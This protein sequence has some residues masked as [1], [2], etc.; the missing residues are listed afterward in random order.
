MNNLPMT[1]YDCV[2]LYESLQEM[3]PE[4]MK[5]LDVKDIF[6]GNNRRLSLDDAREYE[7]LLKNKLIELKNNYSDKIDTLLSKFKIDDSNNS[8]A[9]LYALFK[10]IKEK[11]LIPCIVFQQ[12]TS[13]CKEIY[14][15][16][17][18]YLEKL[19][20]FNYPYYYEN[21]E[22]RQKYF[23]ESEKTLKK[24]RNNIKVPA[25][26]TNPVQFIE[27]ELERKRED[28]NNKFSLDFIKLVDKQ[29]KTIQNSTKTDAIKTIQ[30]NN[31][32][33]DLQEFMK[34]PKLRYVDVF[35]KHRDFCLNYDNPMSAD[36]IREIKKTISKK[37]DI[38]VTY[39]NA[40]MQGLKRGI[41][42]YTKH[43]PPIYNMVVQRLAQN[44][45]LGFVV[46]DERLALG[47]NMPFRATCILGYKDSKYFSTHN[48]L[49]MIGRSGRR[50][51]D[52]EGHI[53]FANV[54]WRNLMKS[55]LAEIKSPYKHIENYTV[56]KEFTNS[57]DNTIENIYKFKMTE[58]SEDQSLIT[59]F[60]FYN[61]K[62]L[63][64]DPG[65]TPEYKIVPDDILNA[66]LWKLRKFN[67]RSRILC[68]KLFELNNN[69][70]IEANHQSVVLLVD[71]LIDIL[72]KNTS[73]QKNKLKNIL[74]SNKLIDNSYEEY[75]LIHNIMKIIKTIYNSLINDSDDNYNFLT[76]HLKL[77]FNYLKTIMFNSND[78]N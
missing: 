45:E 2:K 3:F 72:Y 62:I 53:I 10:E 46:A 33:K 51:K 74:K 18:Q 26:L 67:G 77:S 29:I 48:Y 60:K 71:L 17:V 78:L 21:L 65:D 52:C 1:P 12:N 39:T 24:F 76:K 28:I 36:K 5:G 47:I 6:S 35:Q 64:S 38:N 42:I 7:I 23:L 16:L 57:F 73:D 41:G 31:L 19:E 37:L 54:D 4:K 55:E 11:K 32:K 15:K 14:C 66:I 9:N 70:R 25:D 69:F 8:E 56:I 44:G 68:N 43:M 20:Q 63:I 75:M 27:D 61:K 34:N 49:Q 50:G 59:N 30:I 58:S 22:Y 40:F 13:Y